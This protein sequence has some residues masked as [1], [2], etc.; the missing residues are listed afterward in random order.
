MVSYPTGSFMSVFVGCVRLR[1]ILG[2]GDSG[3]TTYIIIVH[4]TELDTQPS[5]AGEEGGIIADSLLRIFLGAAIC[6]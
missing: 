6:K 3:D 1:A 5:S 4:N 2:E